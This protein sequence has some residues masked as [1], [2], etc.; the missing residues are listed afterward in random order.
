MAD[1][2]L[3][4]VNSILNLAKFSEND[5]KKESHVLHFVPQIFDSK[6]VKLLEITKETLEYIKQGER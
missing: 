6:E 5:I 1:R 2:K 4:Q 3:K